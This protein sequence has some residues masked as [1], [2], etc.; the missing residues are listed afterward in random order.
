MLITAQSLS[1]QSSM[2]LDSPSVK[3]GFSAWFTVLEKVKKK[4][5]LQVN[6]KTK[7][8]SKINKWIIK[9]LLIV[10]YLK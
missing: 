6:Y 10:F 4:G 3:W 1:E 2:K 5:D 8:T 9:V 7:N